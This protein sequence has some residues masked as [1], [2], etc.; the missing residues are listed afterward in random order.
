MSMVCCVTTS[1]SVKYQKVRKAAVAA[2]RA[3]RGAASWVGL[4]LG[5]G[6]RVGVGVGVGLG[7][8]VGRG[9]LTER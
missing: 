6:V 5:L 4:G 2:T 3:R 1:L 7:V 9:H 8:G